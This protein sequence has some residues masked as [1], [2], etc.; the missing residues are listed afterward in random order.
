MRLTETFT[1]MK[2]IYTAAQEG[3]KKAIAL[4]N[5]LEQESK[6]KYQVV[7]D[8]NH[9]LYYGFYSFGYSDAKTTSSSFYKYMEYCKE[10]RYPSMRFADFSEKVKNVPA[11][12]YKEIKAD[13]GTRFKE[14]S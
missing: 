1:S 11:S 2:D 13:K 9:R 10:N 12:E 6:G 4:A 3:D 5:K 7:F 14:L 8:S